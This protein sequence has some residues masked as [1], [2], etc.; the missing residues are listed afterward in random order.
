[1]G[2]FSALLPTPFHLDESMNFFRK[3]AAPIV[4][5]VSIAFLAWMV[6]NLSGITGG[7]GAA[8]ITS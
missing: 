7:G 3:I 8:M 6:F 1:M 4:A 5:V 2:L